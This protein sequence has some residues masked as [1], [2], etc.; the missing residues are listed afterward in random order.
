MSRRRLGFACIVL[1]RP[2]LKAGDT[3]RWQSN[4]HLRV[5]IGYLHSIFDYLD[6]LDIRM[7]RISSGVAPYIT[8]PDLPQF[9]NQIEECRDE[10]AELGAKAR[11]YDLRLSMHPDQY[12]LLNALDDV[13]FAASVRDLD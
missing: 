2:G 11:R 8:H 3:R 4:P 12:T 5:S 9:W 7:Y 6:E 13:V 1:G 10:L